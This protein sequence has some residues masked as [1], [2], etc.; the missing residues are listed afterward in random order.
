MHKNLQATILFVDFTKAFDSIHRRKM[1]QILL[2][3]GLSKETMAAIM[4]L[5]RNIKVKVCFP[6][7]D[8]DYFN[9]VAGILQGDTL[10][11]TPLSSV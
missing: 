4:I 2:T 9:I 11:H 3:F 5:H 6:D 1:E 7:G 8:T 10:P